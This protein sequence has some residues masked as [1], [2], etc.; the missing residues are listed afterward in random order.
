MIKLLFIIFVTKQLLGN[1]T[2]GANIYAAKQSI[3]RQG[4]AEW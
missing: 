4:K 2:S 3:S 1:V